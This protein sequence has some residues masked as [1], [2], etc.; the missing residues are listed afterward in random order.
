MADVAHPKQGFAYMLDVLHHLTLPALTLAIVYVAQYSRLSRTSMIDVLHA[1]YIR[2]ARAKGLGEFIVVF[3]H[4]LRN[5]MI[6]VVTI[7]GL[8]RSEESR[9]GKAC[10]STV[11]SW[12]ARYN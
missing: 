12:W 10:V 7:V 8:Q 4:A 11:T 5:A 6:P 9:A 2:T 3:Q 1:D